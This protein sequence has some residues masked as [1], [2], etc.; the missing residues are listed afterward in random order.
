MDH[1]KGA[2][3]VAV[4]SLLVVNGGE[5][6]AV[7]AAGGVVD[8]LA[9]LGIEDF[10]HHPHHTTGGVE[11]TSLVAAVNV[12]EL[13]NEVLIGITEDVGLTA[14]LPSEIEESPRSG[15]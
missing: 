3:Q 10:E 6:H 8:R 12:G 11:L 14:L 13:T 5:Q 9:L 7:G 1:L 4:V 2:D 15:P